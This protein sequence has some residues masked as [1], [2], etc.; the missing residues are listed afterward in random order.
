MNSET[1]EATALAASVPQDV[2]MAVAAE[3]IGAVL[4][5]FREDVACVQDPENRLEGLND[6][7]TDFDQ[8]A[9]YIQDYVDQIRTGRWTRETL[10]GLPAK[11]IVKRS[12]WSRLLDAPTFTRAKR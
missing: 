3:A 7:G 2:Y 9:E 1:T 8:A 6:A 5:T 12:F 11:A 4:N 10:L